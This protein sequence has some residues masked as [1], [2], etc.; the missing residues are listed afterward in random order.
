L[1]TIAP[2]LLSEL[3]ATEATLVRKLDPANAAAKSIEKITVDK[4][5]FESMHAANR[6][7]SDKLAEGID[8]F[9]KALV[10][11]EEL[12]AARLATLEA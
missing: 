4:A 3:Q 7:A 12:L 8:G 2:S 5:T 9:A 1:L 6:M 11:L 10:T